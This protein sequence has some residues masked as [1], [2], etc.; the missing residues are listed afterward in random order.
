MD[1]GG[2]NL[3]RGRV[4]PEMSKRLASQQADRNVEPAG[5]H[6]WFPSPPPPAKPQEIAGQALGL[7]IGRSLA[8]ISAASW[9]LSKSRKASSDL[10]AAQAG[11][12]RAATDT[13]QAGRL[14]F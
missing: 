9:N 6:Y 12:E 10:C 1:S 8:C 14:G 11:W 13:D 3:A 2:K 5:R 4:E 7:D